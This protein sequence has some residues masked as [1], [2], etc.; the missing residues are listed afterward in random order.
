[1][2]DI[3]GKIESHTAFWQKKDFGRPLIGYCE[4]WV[5]GPRMLRSAKNLKM[6]LISPNDIKPGDF[7]PVFAKICTELESVNDDKIIQTEP[8]APLP[9]M[10]AY[11]RCGLR[12]SGT[13]I[14]SEKALKGARPWA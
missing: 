8:L 14:W 11:F 4:G 1:M 7:L 6:G 12:Y 5:Y 2:N 10:E 9:W 3:P 13:H